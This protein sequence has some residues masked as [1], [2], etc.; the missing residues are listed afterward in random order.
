M[1][2]MVIIV[3][4]LVLH[5]LVKLQEKMLQVVLVLVVQF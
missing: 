5:L 3:N 4:N 1:G 2:K